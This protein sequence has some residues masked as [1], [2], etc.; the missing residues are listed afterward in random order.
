MQ[1]L[2]F[3]SIFFLKFQNIL[4]SYYRRYC[5][6]QI[7]FQARRTYSPS[8]WQGK[9]SAVSLLWDLPLAGESLQRWTVSN[10][11]LPWT[12]TGQAPL[13]QLGTLLKAPLTSELSRGQLRPLVRLL[14]EPNFSFCPYLFPS[15]PSIGVDSE[16]LLINFFQSLFPREPDIQQKPSGI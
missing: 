12:Y 9:R 10:S 16:N 1:I 6:S 7:P 2:F 15:S 11:W 4:V 8:C 14:S 13:P 3:I 5:V